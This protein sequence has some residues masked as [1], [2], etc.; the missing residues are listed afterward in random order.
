MC[1]HFSMQEDNVLQHINVK[2][3]LCTHFGVSIHVRRPRPLY[4]SGNVYSNM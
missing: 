1:L 3:H 4:T 2:C